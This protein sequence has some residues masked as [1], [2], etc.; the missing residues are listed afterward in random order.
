MLEDEE[1]IDIG[2]TGWLTNKF[3]FKT[4]LPRKTIES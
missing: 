1:T 3:T 2:A 4:F